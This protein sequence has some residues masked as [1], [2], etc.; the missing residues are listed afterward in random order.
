MNLILAGPSRPVNTAFE[1]RKRLQDQTLASIGG[2]R[3]SDRLS[4]DAVHDRDAIR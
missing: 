3:A 2:F 4:R 1:R